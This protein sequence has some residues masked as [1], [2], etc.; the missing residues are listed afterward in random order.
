M[1]FPTK[2]PSFKYCSR[3]YIGIKCRTN[4]SIN[5]D[6]EIDMTQSVK[7]FIELLEKYPEIDKIPN[8]IN[9]GFGHVTQEEIP[10]DVKNYFSKRVL[11]KR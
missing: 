9:I 5:D 11:Q 3:Y 8:E 1:Q 10:T 7:S 4:S 6:C 2:H